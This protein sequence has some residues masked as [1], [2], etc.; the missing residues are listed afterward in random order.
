M[1]GIVLSGPGAYGLAE[2][3]IPDPRPD[4]LLLR[5]HASGVCGTDLHL[6]RGHNLNRVRYP[7]VPGQFLNLQELIDFI[8]AGSVKNLLYGQRGQ[9][10]GRM[11]GF[12]D[13]PNTTL[14]QTDGMYSPEMVAAVA[15]YEANLH[16]EPYRCRVKGQFHHNLGSQSVLIHIRE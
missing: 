16:D 3:P 9:G 13:N 4:E 1:K 6:L 8:D 12:G 11:P 10:S 7:V 5:V 15:T 14:D 2:L